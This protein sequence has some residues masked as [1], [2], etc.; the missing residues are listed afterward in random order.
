[1]GLISKIGTR[2][3]NSYLRRT[4]T[5]AAYKEYR[6]IVKD[7]EKKLNTTSCTKVEI[8][9]TPKT[10][11][12]KNG[13]AKETLETLQTS[14]FL[15]YFH[16]LLGKKGYKCPKSIYL[17]E[18]AIPRES[19]IAGMAFNKDLIYN[20][21]TIRLIDLRVPIHET[22]HMLTPGIST[23]ILANLR[24]GHDHYLFGLGEKLKKIPFFKKF[25]TE[26]QICH[27][28]RKEQQILAKDLK[29]AYEEGYLRH[30]PAGARIREQIENCETKAKARQC[31]IGSNR[32]M[33]DFHKN[34]VKY[35]MPNCQLN[36]YE[37]IADY[38]NLAAQGFKFSPEITAKYERYRGPKICEIIT[39]EDMNNLDKLRKQISKKTLADY[40]Y[41]ITA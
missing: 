15:E 31:R 9:K 3:H 14:E 16:S 27:L 20:P 12:I 4:A 39:K 23:P 17:S 38:F 34:P 41:T 36:R 10:A 37:F 25:F 8:A 22:G 6:T 7:W 2:I 29:R 35:Y 13:F 24:I 21:R 26:T 30:N 28:T 19:G 11:V 18:G 32:I 33:K 1:M 40:G 5:R